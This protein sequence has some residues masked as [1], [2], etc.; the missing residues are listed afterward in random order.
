MDIINEGLIITDDKEKMQFNLIVEMLQNTYWARKWSKET[1]KVAME[2]S[3][4]FG[5]ISEGKQI[6]YARCVTDN[7]TMYWLCDVV[8]SYEYRNQGIGKK[9]IH[10]IV[11]HNKLKSLMGILSSNHAK[12]FYKKYGFKLSVNGFMIK[13]ADKFPIE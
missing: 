8:V 11:T 5:V 6:A 10:F 12:D 13:T 2:N 9:L 4:C 7:A 3:M 1:I